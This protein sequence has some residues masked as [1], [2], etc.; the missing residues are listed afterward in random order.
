G[1]VE[2]TGGR[3]YI[4]TDHSLDRLDTVTG[5]IRHF[6]TADGL[7]NNQVISSFRD[8][9]GALWFSTNTGLSRLTPEPDHPRPPPVA[10]INRLQ[11][12]GN[13][14]SVSELGE[15]AVS[16]LG[17]AGSPSNIQIEFGGVAFGAGGGPR[18]KHKREGVNQGCGP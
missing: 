15:A 4:G 16:G 1:I 3:L 9:Q 18:F 14:Y 10:L 11:I 13:P 17:L 7:A 6:T 2:E 5:R 8:S 12:S